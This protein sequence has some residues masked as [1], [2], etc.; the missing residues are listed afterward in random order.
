MGRNPVQLSHMLHRI[1][2]ALR[3]VPCFSLSPHCLQAQ[4]KLLRSHTSLGY[5]THEQIF[6]DNEGV[7]IN[8]AVTNYQDQACG[9]PGRKL[10]V[11]KDPPGLSYEW[12]RPQQ[13][14][15]V[16]PITD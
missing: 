13:Y 8:Y 4:Y 5:Q 15:I 11:E 14:H 2:R 6:E 10:I 12:D 1:R 9:I 3:H 7:H 16:D